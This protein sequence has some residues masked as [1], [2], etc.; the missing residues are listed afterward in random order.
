[1]SYLTLTFDETPEAA[2]ELHR[3][4]AAWLRTDERLRRSTRL[5]EEPPPPGALGGLAT[6]VELVTAAGPV[7]SAAVGAFGYWLGQRMAGHP[8][9][10]A[11]TLADGTSRSFTADRRDRDLVLAE[12][13]RFVRREQ[14]GQAEARIGP[15]PDSSGGPGSEPS[16]CSA[17]AP[18]P[19]PAS[20]V[21]P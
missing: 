20:P 1:M 4:L 15:G 2:S 16:P 3:S 8:I 17:S 9:S 13:E 11:V 14:A 21:I 12:L 5:V 6:A 18:G 19:D 7:L 10:F